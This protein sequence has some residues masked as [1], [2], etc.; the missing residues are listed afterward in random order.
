MDA[1]Q[2]L[3]TLCEQALHAADITDAE[4]QQLVQQLEMELAVI[5]DLDTAHAFLLVHDIIQ[6]CRQ[7]N[8]L[9]T[10]RG[11]AASS[12]VLWLLGVTHFRPWEY[13]L[14]FSRFLNP[15]RVSAADIDIDVSQRERGRV[16]Q[17]LVKRFG[18]GNVAS[19]ATYPS[20]KLRACVKDVARVCAIPVRQ[21]NQWLSVLPDDP[22]ISLDEALRVPAFARALEAHP[23]VMMGVRALEGQLRHRSIHAGGIVIS[24]R[25]L[26]VPLWY[27]AGHPL[28]IIE[29]DM[30]DLEDAGYTK[31]DI[32]GLR[33]LDVIADTLALIDNLGYNTAF[34]ALC[35]IPLDDPEVYEMLAAGD[36][37]GVF[38]VEGS[39]QFI[40]LAQDFRPR[41]F[42]DYV[43]LMALYR[44][45]VMESGATARILQCRA[46]TRPVQY[47]IPELEPILEDTYGEMIFQEQAMDIVCTVAGFTLEEADTL[48]YA[49]GKKVTDRLEPLKERFF[50]GA[51]ARGY[52]TQAQDL[53][54]WLLS[55]THYVWNRC[56]TYE[57]QVTLADGQHIVSIEVLYNRYKAGKSLPSILAY[58]PHYNRLRPTGIRAVE[59]QGK[60]TVYRVQTD[61]GWSVR[62]TGDHP[63]YVAD[64][65]QWLSIEDGLS[66]GMHVLATDPRMAVI[67]PDIPYTTRITGIY[68]LPRPMMTYCLETTDPETSNFIANNLIVHN[69]H[70]VAYGVLSMATAWL[71]RH[72]GAAF[73]TALL[74]S[75]LSDRARCAHILAEGRSHFTLRAPDLRES[76]GD[77]SYVPPDGLRIG[78]K[79]IKGI[80]ANRYQQILDLRQKFPASDWKSFIEVYRR[81]PLDVLA[82]LIRS[83]AL[84]Y[85]GYTRA[86]MLDILH[87]AV[88]R[89]RKNYTIPDPE[90][91]PEFDP[92]ERCLQEYASTGIY[93][94]A[95]PLDQYH[96]EQW[97]LIRPSAQSRLVIGMIHNSRAW[98]TKSGKDMRFVDLQTRG[99][100]ESFAVFSDMLDTVLPLL[101]KDTPV[102]VKL[103]LQPRG[104]VCEGIWGLDSAHYNVPRLRLFLPHVPIREEL[105]YLQS[106]L[107]DAPDGPT[108]VDIAIP[109]GQQWLVMNLGITITATAECVGELSQWVDVKLLV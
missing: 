24:D 94:S 22:N 42:T 93:I 34:D 63:F 92:I 69:S 5:S 84:D 107:Q 72:H 31:L 82:N 14:R 96:T 81:L 40:Q 75:E 52:G 7:E 4:R 77:F 37:I 6:Y 85:L 17:Y 20:M 8:I 86:A 46:G 10:I 79:A 95:H 64:V 47:I 58:H 25:P 68:Q 99:G 73:F 53:W 55:S 41:N 51:Q 108:A 19:I 13:H 90:D 23:E 43:L 50:E 106:V 18:E 45:S 80:G 62:V 101:Q 36:S 3:R 71:K 74:N 28:P 87:V 1:N 78:L 39:R 9:A 105:I 89:A 102:A 21:V 26:T 66:V 38:Q 2:Y 88:K 56:V 27:K 30:Y 33:T 76:T 91:V 16:L 70:G 12:V 98:T 104:A 57:T 60:Q 103:R 83:G 54:D 32:L 109:I 65:G 44:T 11:S 35:H 29:W 100:I 15:H 49:I 61:A 97:G 67:V 59:R 48:R